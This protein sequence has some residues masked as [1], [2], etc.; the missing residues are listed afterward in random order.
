MN[1][2]F[3]RLNNLSCG[4][5]GKTILSDVTFDIGKGD[6]IGIIGPNGAGKTTLLKTLTGHL[7]P[8]RGSID[9][10]TRPLGKYSRKELAAV[11]AVVGQTVQASLLTVREYVLLGRIPFFGKYQVFES[12]TDI[13]VADRYMELTGVSAF[14]DARMNE[15]SGG[16]RQLTAITRA[17]VQEPQILLLDEPTSHLD[18]THQQRIMNLIARL[19]RD[20]ELT[21][22]MV[23][24]DLN[25]AAEYADRLIL[26]DRNTRR[27]Y[28]SG[29]AETVLTGQSVKDIYR[30]DVH[31][32][33]N[34]VSGRP[35]IFL[36]KSGL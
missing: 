6:V 27:V 20:L 36:H 17:L 12:R 21:V 31:V 35:Y 14:E 25:L 18:I 19:N 11:M 32:G 4:Y 30:T 15:I 23:M 7:K 34:P 8:G 13:E 29:P 1:D 9:I 26:L 2:I 24:H 28:H 3:I 16:E 22:I 10:D 33:K 5:P